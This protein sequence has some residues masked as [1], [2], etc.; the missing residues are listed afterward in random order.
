[1][2]RDSDGLLVQ[3][4]LVPLG[5]QGTKT[6]IFVILSGGAKQKSTSCPVA[7]SLLSF[8]LLFFYLGGGGRG[9]LWF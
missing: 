7:R 5:D 4:E 1:M 8:L 9:G 6:S 2:T 3:N